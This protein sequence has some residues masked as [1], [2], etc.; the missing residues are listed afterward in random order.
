MASEQ[1][2]CGCNGQI[3]VLFHG[4]TRN[5]PSRINQIAASSIDEPL[6]QSEKG[7]LDSVRSSFADANGN[8][9]NTGLSPPLPRPIVPLIAA[10]LCEG[11]AGE[12]S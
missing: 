12:A 10:V 6:I 11:M 4:T 3:V 9:A 5:D 7:V 1:H 2:A 8:V